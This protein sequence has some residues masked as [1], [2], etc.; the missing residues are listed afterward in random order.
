[1]VKENALCLSMAAFLNIKLATE[2]VNTINQITVANMATMRRFQD[3]D[4]DTFSEERVI[5]YLK[6]LQVADP[7]LQNINVSFARKEIERQKMNVPDLENRE[8]IVNSIQVDVESTHSIYDGDEAV[9]SATHPFLKIESNGT[10]K[11][12]NVL[13]VIFNALENGSVVA[14][15]EIENGL[16]PTIVKQLVDLFYSPESNPYNA[17]LICTTHN[18]ML[19][20]KGVRRDQVWV[21][22]K[23]SHGISSLCRISDIPGIR[24]Y[25]NSGRKYLD[26]AFG[27]IPDSIFK[28]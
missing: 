26:K 2:L 12:F 16:H 27:E 13:P 23:D 8:L 4:E 14:I 20:D 15:D 1:V 19:I 3:V 11:L 25:E 17:Q 10:I 7:T 6:I 21:I 18:S 22:S 5:R 24:A 28:E 9:G